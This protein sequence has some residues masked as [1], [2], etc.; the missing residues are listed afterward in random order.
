MEVSS[1][2]RLDA[3][4]DTLSY[5]CNKL[6]DCSSISN[7]QSSN[8]AAFCDFEDE[9]FNGLVFE[10]RPTLHSMFYD[11]S[12]EV[13]TNKNLNFEDA[14]D[15]YEM[16][17]DFDDNVMCEYK[18]DCSFKIQPETLGE[19]QSEGKLKIYDIYN[20]FYKVEYENFMF[21]VDNMYESVSRD[22]F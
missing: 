4:G 9:V 8:D 17:S 3:N 14:S 20:S 22:E 21:L 10:E 2:A 18:Y 1:L 19:M 7:I 15:G 5:C 11:D 6:E 13:K 16:I 12:N